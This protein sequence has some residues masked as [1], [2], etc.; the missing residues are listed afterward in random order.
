MW[1]LIL[2]TVIGFMMHNVVSLNEEISISE[3]KK[4]STL[5]EV[6]DSYSS[7]FHHQD[8]GCGCKQNYC[9]CCEDAIGD[10]C[11]T[12]GYYEVFDLPAAFG[13]NISNNGVPFV[14][15]T[16]NV[17]HLPCIHLPY[18][19]NVAVCLQLHGFNK[20]SEYVKVLFDLK[21]KL[22]FSSF[23]VPLGCLLIPRLHPHTDMNKTVPYG[24]LLKQM[25]VH[26]HPNDLTGIGFCNSPN[27]ATIISPMNLYSSLLL[28]LLLKVFMQ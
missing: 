16:V 1:K 15:V 9:M 27:L 28:V 26:K 17:T 19:K 24:S 18:I 8:T 2:L 6:V 12:I 7:V 23:N 5:H 11:I 21:A 10:V 20:T 22:S 4:L 13:V 3:D 14:T 25:G